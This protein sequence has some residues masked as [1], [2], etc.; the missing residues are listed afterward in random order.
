MCLLLNRHETQ[1]F[2]IN[3]MNATLL[4]TTGKT[5]SLNSF[6]PY[7]LTSRKENADLFYLQL[8]KI[9]SQVVET[10]MQHFR[11][12]LN[13]F[14]NSE[15]F[16]KGKNNSENENLLEI[17][18]I[19]VF[20]NNY[21]GRWRW[22]IGLIAPMF[23]LIYKLRSTS[24]KKSVDA[25]KGSLGSFLLN[26]PIR[27]DLPFDI[28]NFDNLINWL[29]ATGDFKMEVRMLKKWSSFLYTGLSRKSYEFLAEASAF[30]EWFEKY[31][32]SQ[33]GSYTENVE[34]FLQHNKKLLRGRE[35]QFFCSR[36][37]VEYHMNMVG[38]QIMNESLNDEFQKTEK[39]ILLLPTCMAK[40]SNCKAT[41]SEYALVCQN[42]TP[43]CNISKTKEK[44]A[45]IGVETI[46]IKH[47]S[48]FSKWIKPWAN[49]SNTGLIGTA[50]VLNLLG[51]GYEMKQMGIPSQCVY[52]NYSGCKKHWSKTGIATEIN[53]DQV[54]KLLKKRGSSD[55]LNSEHIKSRSM[56]S[57]I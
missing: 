50:C 23:Q 6:Q 9:T 53:I 42:C 24:L 34:S 39:K 31:T 37:Q 40:S 44:M 20:W 55:R 13:D 38:A 16:S 18:M 30:A 21:Q 8:E 14:R 4:L 1:T 51:G 52:L 2:I 41:I 19:G 47:S 27:S 25:L 43:D 57:A 32:K 54:P 45:N 26:K 36:T 12:D 15:Q 22:N 49:Q 35:D 10:G 46:L 48:D 28:D 11:N 7:N 17:L 33:L 3:K 5:I 29:S 56:A